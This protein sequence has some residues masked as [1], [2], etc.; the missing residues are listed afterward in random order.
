MNPDHRPLQ[1]CRS[2]VVRLIVFFILV[3][4]P[5][6]SRV[7]RIGDYRVGVRREFSR[8]IH[9]IL[10]ERKA[11]CLMSKMLPHWTGIKH[12]RGKGLRYHRPQQGLES[13]IKSD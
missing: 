8:E 3:T 4:K 7:E 10:K 13:M 6:E 12:R 5:K 2:Y 11:I 1:H 9:S